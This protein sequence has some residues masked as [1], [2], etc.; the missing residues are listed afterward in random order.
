MGINRRKNSGSRKYYI[1]ELTSSADWV[2]GEV[3][4]IGADSTNGHLKLDGVAYAGP[5]EIRKDDFIAVTRTASAAGVGS[6]VRLTMANVTGLAAGSEIDFTI[7]NIILDDRAGGQLIKKTFKIVLT[8]TDA[9]STTALNDRILSELQGFFGSVANHYTVTEQSSTTIDIEDNIGGSLAHAKKN[10]YLEGEVELGFTSNST[11]VTGAVTTNATKPEGVRGVINRFVDEADFSTGDV[12]TTVTVEY[13]D[14]D[15][16]GR[17]RGDVMVRSQAVIYYNE[18]DIAA[19]ADLG[20]ALTYLNS[21]VDHLVGYSGVG[22]GDAIK[23]TTVADIANV[24]SDNTIPVG[25]LS[26]EVAPDATD[27]FILIS[28]GNSIGYRCNIHNSHASQ[29]VRVEPPATVAFTTGAAGKYAELDT[30]D[31]P[32]L[33]FAVITPTLYDVASSSGIIVTIEA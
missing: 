23:L 14:R 3:C 31:N 13:W 17:A 6:V 24:K 21:L 32:M 7:K 25:A 15:A 33:S 20:S 16:D 5:L 28:D 12:Y 30:S 19:A 1:S 29:D 11:N 18:T 22:V 26:V 2:Y 10:G 9:A 8:A 27:E 4:K